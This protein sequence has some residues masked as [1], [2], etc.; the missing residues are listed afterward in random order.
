MTSPTGRVQCGFTLVELLAVISM[1]AV[2]MGLTLAAVQRVRHAAARVRCANNLRQ[3]ALGLSNYQGA[4]GRLPPGI[5]TGPPRQEP[6]PYLSWH[7]RILPFVEQHAI[8]QQ[9]QSAYRTTPDFL[10]SPPHPFAT[11]V[12]IYGCPAD[13]RTRSTGMARGQFPAAFTSYLGVSGVRTFRHNGVLYRNSR[14]R[15]ADIR[16]GMSNTL[17]VGER[18]PSGDLWTGWWHAGYGCDSAGRGDM[19]LGVRDGSGGC[20]WGLTQCPTKPVGFRAG[21]IDNNCDA[22]H[23]W[24]VHAGGANFAFCD[25]SVRFLSYSA[26]PILP[27]LATREGGE[28]V[29]VP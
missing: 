8:W 20:I 28:S 21:K 29:Q 25:G 18:P 26:D 9:A 11:P 14:T 22:L 17:L 13:S 19:V 6:F 1:I 3:I 23:F 12:P 7:A 10:I 24:S 4:H 5:S 27:A 16:D 2:L 15:S